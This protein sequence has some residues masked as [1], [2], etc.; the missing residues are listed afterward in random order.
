MSVIHAIHV[1]VHVCP[2]YLR[3]VG[4]TSATMSDVTFHPGIVMALNM[5]NMRTAYTSVWTKNSKNTDIVERSKLK[6]VKRNKFKF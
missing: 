4:Y 2:Q 5:H 6:A 3:E 1:T